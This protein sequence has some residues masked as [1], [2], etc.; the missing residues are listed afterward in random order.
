[1]SRKKASN[2]LAIA[3]L[4]ISLAATSAQAALILV[5]P[6][7]FGGTGL[8]A[9]NTILTVQ[10][11]GNSTTE[12]GAVSF[13]GVTDVRTGDASNAGTQ[14]R[15]ISSLG[16][17]SASDVRVVFNALEP[18]NAEN[19]IT[20]TSLVLSIFSPIGATLFSSGP[21]TPINFTDTFTGAGNSGFVFR[22]DAPDTLAAQALGFGVGSGANRI[23]LSASATNA[24]GGFET[25]FVGATVTTVVPVP[26][27]A[28][29]GLF[30]AALL[31]LWGVRR[32]GSKS[33]QRIA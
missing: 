20:L 21:F 30:S 18:G 26:E 6:E 9:V 1:M 4:G 17:A 14:T 7:N 25:F 11:A 27:P 23:G 31:G 10:S 16:V 2:A 13:N 32:K 33:D 19:S 12:T 28:T 22:L 15:T 5:S 8:G 3:A 24:T 29:L